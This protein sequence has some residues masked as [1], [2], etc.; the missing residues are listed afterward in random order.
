[1]HA[2]VLPSS[3]AFAELFFSTAAEPHLLSA[4]DIPDGTMVFIRCRTTEAHSLSLDSVRSRSEYASNR[5]ARVQLPVLF[6]HT[7]P[8]DAAN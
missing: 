8:T 7:P 6:Q 5:H 2:D 3:P 4:T 1:M